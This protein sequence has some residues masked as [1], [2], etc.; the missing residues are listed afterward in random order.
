MRMAFFL[1]ALLK[2][3]VGLSARIMSHS[4]LIGTIMAALDA[5]LM[6]EVD[7]DY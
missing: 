3:A 5:L 7:V 6:I 4:C 1:L 2:D